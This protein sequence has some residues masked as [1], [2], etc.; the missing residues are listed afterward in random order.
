MGVAAGDYD[1]DGF[2]DLYVTDYGGNTLYRNKRRRH[3]R[4]RDA[5]GRRRGR[6]VE[7]QRRVLRLRQRRQARSLRDPLRRVELPAQSLL[8][9]EEARLPRLLSSR[10]LRTASRTCSI[11]TTATARSPTSPRRPASPMPAGKGLG[12]AF[13]DYDG[14]GFV[15][16]YVANDSVQSFLYRNNGTAR[17]RRSACS[18]AS[19]SPRTARPSPAWAWTSPTTTTTAGPTSSSPTCRTSATGCSGR[20]ATAASA[21]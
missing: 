11:A 8:R 16:V 9:R 13:A 6:R 2:P 3:V 21:T 18:P 20:T 10:Q 5:G 12:V 17:S 4:R 1:N 15:D 7:R 19:G 14:D